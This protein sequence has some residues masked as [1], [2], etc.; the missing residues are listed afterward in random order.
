MMTVGDDGDALNNTE[1]TREPSIASD[2]G[3]EQV[4]TNDLEEVR[5]LP[6]ALAGPR[7][8]RLKWL[9]VPETVLV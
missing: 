3:L 8:R 2:H 1:C 9:G 7:R 5:F 6:E 4:A